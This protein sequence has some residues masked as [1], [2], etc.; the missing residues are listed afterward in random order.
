MPNPSELERLAP[1]TE[2]N[3]RHWT[4]DLPTISGHYWWRAGEGHA[5]VLRNVGVWRGG[6]FVT[7]DY[8]ISNHSD[9]C[10]PI[11]DVKGDWFG[12][13]QPPD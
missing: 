2:I 7:R 6:G 3:G 12:P 4:H 1:T 9:G 11:E 13:L 8:Q 5:A 10:V